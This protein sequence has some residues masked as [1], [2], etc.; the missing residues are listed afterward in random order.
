MGLNLRTLD[1]DPSWR[2]T[3]N[4]LSHPGTLFSF[5]FKPQKFLFNTCFPWI[6]C[7]LLK[8][9][10]NERICLLQFLTMLESWD[11]S[12]V[13]QTGGLTY[14]SA[15]LELVWFISQTRSTISGVPWHHTF[16]SVLMAR[17]HILV[18]FFQIMFKRVF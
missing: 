12:H 5:I 14:P 18:I 16:Q 2:Q 9:I 17:I 7:T 15:I 10:F 11:F 13:N 6:F 4:Q 3:L 1:H 8:F